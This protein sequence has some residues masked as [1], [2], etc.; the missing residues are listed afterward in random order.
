MNKK[1]LIIAYYFP[2]MG[3]SGVQRTLKFVK[4]L[5]YYGWDPIVVTTNSPAYYAF[6]DSLL[7][8]LHND[9]QIYRTD[10]DITKYLKK[11]KDSEKTTVSYPSKFKQK[12]G[13]I[14]SQTV[15]QPD[16]RI[17]WKKHALKACEKA[18][19]ENNIEAIY[20]TAPPF[21]DFLIAKEI[22]QKYGIPFIVDYRD[23]WIDNAFYFY[24][25]PFHKN[26]SIKL[27]SEVLK[28]S[29][30]SIVITRY[31][32]EMLLKRYS[33]ISHDDIIIIPHG[34][35]KED[36]DIEYSQITGTDKFV[37][38]H[39][40]LFP[41]DL[42]PK[43]FLQA[44]AKFVDEHNLSDKVKANFLGV[45]RKEHIKLIKKYGLE[46]IV[47]LYGYVPHNFSVKKLMESDIL[48]FMITNNIATPSRMFE[49]IGSGKPF[50]A[51][52]PD[53]SMKE[54]ANE[55]GVAISCQPN[56]V[57]DIYNAL[58]SYY[59]MWKRGT[60]PT[61]NPDFADKYD[62]KKLTSVLAKE[63]ELIA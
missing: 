46:N 59:N 34:Y 19:E 56:N 38:T 28:Y 27:E 4:Y 37:I 15:F 16:S 14:V 3:L 44:L 53:G 22:S 39:S 52:V 1:V 33:V 30:K 60:L 48:W 58:K 18:V 42:T 41:D 26:Y 11:N 61:K 51:C 6:D 43:Y 55:S 57:D 63:L 12:F 23:L 25:T 2:P 24:A 29:S 49:Y 47:E 54:I 62:R 45:M 17:T 9:I 8:E 7:D 31:M 13:R 10:E 36:F 5:P 35:D 32:K 20:A 40:G 50:I 21:T